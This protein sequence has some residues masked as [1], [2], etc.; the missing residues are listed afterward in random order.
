VLANLRAGLD[1]ASRSRTTK[2]K[3]SQD[4]L[5]GIWSAW[6]DELNLPVTLSHIT[7]NDARAAETKVAILIAFGYTYRTKGQREHSVKADTVAGALRAVG[8]GIARLDGHDPRFYGSNRDYHPL[9]VD[10][11]KAMRDQDDPAQRAYPCNLAILQRIREVLDTTDPVDGMLN[12]H[13]IDLC[14]VAFYWLMRPSEYTEGTTEESRTEAFCF[15]DIYLTLGSKVYCAPEAPLNDVT[16]I[17]RFTHGVLTFTD[18]KNAVR[19]EQ[20]GHRANS[21]PFF[22]PVKALARIARRMK[23]SGAAPDTPIYRHY[24]P[25]PRH[26]TWYSTKSTHITNALRHAAQSM[27]DT[28]GI[29]FHLL[30]ARSLRP[31]GA[32][33]LMCASVDP[34]YVALLGRWKSDAMFRYLRTQAASY[35]QHLSQAMLDHG[36]YTFAPGAINSPD[37]LPREAPPKLAELLAHQELYEDY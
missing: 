37:Q 32:T 10:F 27:E 3:K 5:F 7:G 36:A 24:N 29:P 8:Q 17:S 15:Q 35:H 25:H 22:C 14:I 2:T 6:C 23:L 1:L 12:A 16:N 34:D 31:G 9:L 13:V 21:D 26:R 28:T 30:S 19:G 20:V 4:K 33:A 18:Q 11:F